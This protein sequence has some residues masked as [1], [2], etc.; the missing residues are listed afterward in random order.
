[1]N[2]QLKQIEE[3]LYQLKKLDSNY[4]LFGS[5]KHRYHLNPPISSEKIEKFELRNKIS[6]PN[7]YKEFLINVGN[8]G[9]GP[10]YG[11]E[12][13][14]NALFEDL[15]YKDPM[16][17]LDPSNLFLHTEPWNLNFKPTLDEKENIEE[18]ELQLQEF[19][20]IYFDSKQLNGVIAICNYGCGISLNLVVNGK[21]YGNIWTND[22]VNNNGIHPSYE[23]GNKGKITFL[24]WYELWLNNSLDKIETTASIRDLQVEKTQ[25]AANTNTAWWKF[26]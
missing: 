2:E 21:E 16:S 3:K 24:N 17:L 20:E 1:M 25:K 11:L 15:D 7:D 12:P 23:L 6:L 22:R 13:L 8:G 9:A 19:E 4:S 10:F 18:Y 14:E 5:L 26:W